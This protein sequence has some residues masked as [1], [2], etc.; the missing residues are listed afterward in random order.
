ML[1]PTI[2]W[3][4]TW[5]SLGADFHSAPSKWDVPIQTSFGPLPQIVP[6]LHRVA[7]DLG[8]ELRDS[9]AG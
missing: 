9:V 2:E 8:V 3:S 6:V 1:L 5:K 7:A 4:W